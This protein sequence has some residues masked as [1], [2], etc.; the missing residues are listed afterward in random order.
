[1]GGP[2]L[3]LMAS[4][5]VTV[6]KGKRL[7]GQSLKR[8]EDP[9]F[10]TGS[11]GY[12]DDLRFPNTL[13]AAFVRSPHAHAKIVSINVE[14]ALSSPGV[15]GA[16]TGKDLEG[17]V[18][19]MPTVDKAGSEGGVSSGAGLWHRQVCLQGQVAS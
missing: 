2:V 9:K 11:G 10:M 6:Q 18:A 12:L 15:F 5:Q 3:S 19:S 13:Y 1:M 4:A 7:V 17:K 8:T 14:P 16:L